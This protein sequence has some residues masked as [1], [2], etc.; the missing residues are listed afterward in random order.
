[1]HRF[2]RGGVEEEYG[3]LC[4]VMTCA[5]VL[6][7]RWTVPIVHQLQHGRCRFN[8]LRRSLPTMS[9][10]VL[11]RR[12]RYLERVGVV[13]RSDHGYALTPSGQQLKPVLDAMTAWGNRFSCET[14]TLNAG[15]LL[16]TLRQQAVL[17]DVPAR[18]VVVA[19]R[20]AGSA[21]GLSR[22]WMVIDGQLGTCDLCI[23]DP[24]HDVDLTMTVDASCLA[25]YVG[26][27]TT[28][29]HILHFGSLRVSGNRELAAAFPRWFNVAGDRHRHGA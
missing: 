25:A 3:E 5:D 22:F 21:D 4:A 16:W 15:D 14:D 6:A 29:Q 1:M 9:P 8:D 28:W 2:Y 11:F 19:F 18:R 13:T 23:S 7:E 26:G 10:T 17:T 20:V 24:G 27:D 12:L